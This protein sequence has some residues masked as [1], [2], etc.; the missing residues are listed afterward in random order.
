MMMIMIMIITMNV[1]MMAII[2]GLKRLGP[3]GVVLASAYGRHASDIHTNSGDA[4]CSTFY[5]IKTSHINIIW[6]DL[7]E[8]GE[9][10]TFHKLHECIGMQYAASDITGIGWGLDNS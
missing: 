1:K 6:G 3:F 4:L 5:H 7:I 8:S 2:E 9:R 10:M